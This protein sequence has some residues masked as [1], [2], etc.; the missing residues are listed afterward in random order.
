MF[1][2]RWV[3]HRAQEMDKKGSKLSL[4]YNDDFDL[5]KLH[6]SLELNIYWQSKKLTDYYYGV[7]ESEA[8]TSIA[9][10]KYLIAPPTILKTLVFQGLI[11]L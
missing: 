8:K 5:Y 3:Q 10:G 6:L 9:N 4:T 11:F 7:N 1:A 2:T